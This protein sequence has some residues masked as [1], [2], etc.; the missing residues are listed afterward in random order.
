MAVDA[1]DHSGPNGDIQ[2]RDS[3]K[4]NLARIHNEFKD[5]KID[6][7]S[8]ASNG[9][10]AFTLIRFTGTT[11]APMHGMP[12]NTKM[13]SRAVDVVRLKDGMG[14]EHWRFI[15]E[16]EMMKMM[17]AAGDKMGS[18]M[19]DKMKSKTDTSKKH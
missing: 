17:N 6:I 12:A 7:I 1:V 15:D 2:G 4:A 11:V 18:K 14:V 16:A 5:I 19:D 3:I 8:N 13:D 10:Y 9:D